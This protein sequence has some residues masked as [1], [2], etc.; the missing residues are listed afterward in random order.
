M[1]NGVGE[2]VAGG[3]VS[4]LGERIALPERNLFYLMSQVPA[5]KYWEAICWQLMNAVINSRRTMHNALR[6]PM[7]INYKWCASSISLRINVVFLVGVRF[8][9]LNE[10]RR[11]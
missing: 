6:Q 9:D 2:L 11:G 4:I 10:E 7:P 8:A 1:L 5:L 3:S